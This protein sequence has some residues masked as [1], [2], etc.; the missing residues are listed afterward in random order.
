MQQI[1]IKLLAV[2]L[3]T[4]LT[5]CD[6]QPISVGSWQIETEI[7]ADTIQAMWTI[8]ASETLQSTGEWNFSVEQVELDGSRIAF[9]GQI[10]LSTGTFVD[11]N[12]SGTVS[13]NS[14]QGTFFTTEGNFTVSGQ[15]Q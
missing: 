11:G 9:S 8:T 12:F 7:A 15:R 1:R 10:P 3:G 14:L 2:L 13:G 6:I 5:A 4:S